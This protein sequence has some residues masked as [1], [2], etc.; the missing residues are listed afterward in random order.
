MSDK[1]SYFSIHS[2][3]IS[4]LKIVYLESVTKKSRTGD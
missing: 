3:D 2:V 4:Y 1:F